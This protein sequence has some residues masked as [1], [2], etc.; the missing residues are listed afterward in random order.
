MSTPTCLTEKDSWPSKV[1]GVESLLPWKTCNR[2]RKNCCTLYILVTNA[3][4]QPPEYP[5]ITVA[6]WEGPLILISFVSIAVQPRGFSTCENLKSRSWRKKNTPLANCSHF[7]TLPAAENWEI[8]HLFLLCWTLF[9]ALQGANAS[10]IMQNK[11]LIERGY[12]TEETA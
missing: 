7:L 4:H 8:M 12:V 1:G 10:L 5:L 3:S 11:L 2:K 9:L 6:R